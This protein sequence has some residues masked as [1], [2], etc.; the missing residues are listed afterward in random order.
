MCLL[1]LGGCLA[2]LGGGAE[3]A[4]AAAPVASFSVSPPLPRTLEAVTFRSTSTGGATS[5]SWDLDNDGSCDDATGPVARRSFPVAAVYLVRLCVAGPGGTA[6]QTQNVAVANRP[7]V[8]AFVHLPARPETGEAVTFVS[9]SSDPDGPVASLAWDLQ[10]DG[11]FDD[12]SAVVASRSF[13]LPGNYVVRLRVGDRDGAQA[14][15]TQIVRVDPSLIRPFPVV[16]IAGALE[17]SAVHI[18]RL[19]VQAPRQARIAIRCRGKGCPRPQRRR[20]ARTSAR[21]RRFERRL[22]AGALLE[23]F[24]TERG[25][26]G[27]Y[28][29]FKVRRGR[30]PL[31]RDLCL[32]P[33]SKRPRRCPPT[34]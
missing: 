9:T 27:K 17:R 5:E 34:G 8:A 24:V 32:F 16:G 15:A 2:A 21:F 33:G 30:A 13:E 31:R 10:G 11:S 14:T 28:T 18:R 20:R 1:V 25:R 6:E 3:G 23:V 29:S 19:T 12:G 7:P 22:V 4:R 26:I